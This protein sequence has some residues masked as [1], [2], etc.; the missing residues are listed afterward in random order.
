L[1]PASFGVKLI[2]GPSIYNQK[3]LFKSINGYYCISSQ[4]LSQ[5]LSPTFTL[6]RSSLAVEGGLELLKDEIYG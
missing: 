5:Y 4:E 2:T 6:D 1:E 3:E